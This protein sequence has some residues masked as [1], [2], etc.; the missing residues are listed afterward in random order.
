ME[1]WMFGHPVLDVG[2]LVGR[3]VIDDQMHRQGFVGLPVELAQELE[4]LI[5]A[6]FRQ[7]LAN[8]GPAWTSSAA[9]KVVVRLRL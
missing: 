9:N 3:V 2:M 7:A 6:M 5:M 1:P 4:E 8:D